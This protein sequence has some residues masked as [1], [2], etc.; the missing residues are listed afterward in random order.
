MSSLSKYPN[1]T[2]VAFVNR[3]A[4]AKER[5]ET[6]VLEVGCGSANNLWYCALEQYDV[7]GID[8]DEQALEFARSRFDAFYLHGDL[9]KGDLREPLPWEN[10]T[11]DMIID[12]GALSYLTRA[13]LQN[14][15]T[16]LLRVAVPGARFHFSP[17]GVGSDQ[18]LLDYKPGLHAERYTLFEAATLLRGWK[19]L[20]VQSIERRWFSPELAV[21]DTWTRPCVMVE[22][23]IIAEKQE[24][25]T[26]TITY[27]A[28][29]FNHMVTTSE[30]DGWHVL[31]AGMGNEV[32][33]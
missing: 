10:E 14:S 8:M 16:E 5:T 9:R 6:R 33:K 7:S 17:Y 4:P 13:E 11:F 27:T 26:V 30:L 1:D 32:R 28:E 25:T 23:I 2:V 24:R 19:L 31:N 29:E 3:Y 18:R 20:E 15:L 22:H 21:T 12:R